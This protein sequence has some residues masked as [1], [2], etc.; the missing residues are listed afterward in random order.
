[1]QL[2]LVKL[3][4]NPVAFCYDT[5]FRAAHALPTPPAASS[6]AAGT[7]LG[8]LGAAWLV[9]LGRGPGN[10][11]NRDLDVLVPLDF[12]KSKKM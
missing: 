4:W 7:P 5:L 8:A 1:M 6:A 12:Y 2:A 3:S 11:G 9:L 10:D